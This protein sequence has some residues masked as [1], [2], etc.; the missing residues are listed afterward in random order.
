M[1]DPSVTEDAPAAGGPV[2]HRILRVHGGRLVN[3]EPRREVETELDAQAV[4]GYLLVGTFVVDDNV[5]L[6]LRGGAVS[7]LGGSVPVD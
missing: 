3:A 2:S 7:G 1:T 5:Y 6:V 4:D